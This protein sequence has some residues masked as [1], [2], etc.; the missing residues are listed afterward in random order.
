MKYTTASHRDKQYIPRHWLVVT[1][2]GSDLDT[3]NIAFSE[4]SKF[5]FWTR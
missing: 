4:A 3:A 2:D 1:E 5:C